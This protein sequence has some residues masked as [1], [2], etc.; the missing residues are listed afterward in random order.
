MHH[1]KQLTFSNPCPCRTGQLKKKKEESTSSTRQ[2][3]QQKTPKTLPNYDRV[4]TYACIF[5]NKLRKKAPPWFVLLLSLDFVFLLTTLQLI[6]YHPPPLQTTTQCMMG[7]CC[8]TVCFICCSLP[9]SVVTWSD[10]LSHRNELELQHNGSVTPGDVVSF[11]LL[12]PTMQVGRRMVWNS[13]F[14]PLLTTWQRGDSI[15]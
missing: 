8:G 6:Y 15:R 12:F 1:P 9:G 7:A 3:Q 13:L 5:S 10:R 2:D 4:C 11:Q 14:H